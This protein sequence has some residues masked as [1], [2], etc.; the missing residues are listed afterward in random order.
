[1]AF[2]R[3]RYLN[4]LSFTSTR[5]I[6]TVTLPLD[7]ACFMPR[8][9]GHKWI[10]AR[11]ISTTMRYYHNVPALSLPDNMT[12]IYG[13]ETGRFTPER[14]RDINGPVLIYGSSVP[15]DIVDDA[16]T[17]FSLNDAYECSG[18]NDLHVESYDC[19]G[20]VNLSSSMQTN[21]PKPFCST[22]KATHLNMPGG[23]WARDN[24]YI[25]EDM[26]NSHYSSI[27]LQPVDDKCNQEDE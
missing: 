21:V 14:A 16:K 23:Q 5:V 12:E 25:A 20:A 22:G 6:H 17:M 8:G 18:Q 13:N 24:K 2:A 4:D 11:P 26:Q 15:I 1:M 3:I 19:S 10:K 27:K 9:T 7:N